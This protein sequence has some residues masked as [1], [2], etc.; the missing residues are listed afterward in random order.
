MKR[1]YLFDLI[2]DWPV[3]K[4]VYC[5]QNTEWQSNGCCYWIPDEC[6]RDILLQDGDDIFNEWYGIV[7]I[8]RGPEAVFGTVTV[9]KS[10]VT[11]SLQ[12]ST[13]L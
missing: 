2:L 1:F 10:Y 3:L 7:G 11:P 5:D 12:T 13:F 4:L 9:K 8:C 6:D